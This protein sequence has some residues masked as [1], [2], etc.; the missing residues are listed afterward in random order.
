VPSRQVVKL[1]VVPTSNVDL[2][3]FRPA[4]T[5][6]Y[7]R[8]RSRARRGALIGGR[9]ARGPATEAY[10]LENKTEL[11][12]YVYACVYKPRDVSPTASYSLSIT[13]TR[14]GRVP[15]QSAGKD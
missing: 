5:S 13:T 4:A 14:L 1:R 3:L 8:N 9:Y 12:R 11:G 6:C 10:A 7:Y 15:K 2:E